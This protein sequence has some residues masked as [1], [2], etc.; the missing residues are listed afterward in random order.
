M[1]TRFLDVTLGV[2]VAIGLVATPAQASSKPPTS[3][4]AKQVAARAASTISLKVLSSSMATVTALAS[5]QPLPTPGSAT[6][7][8]AL[9]ASST[10]IIRL[11]NALDPT[12]NDAP[13]DTASIYY[14]SS[15]PGCSTTTQCV[16]GDESSSTTVVLYGDSHAQMWLP[17][18]AP[19]ATLDKF[20]LVL[21]WHPGCPVA[22]VPFSWPVCR[23]FRIAAIAAI[24]KLKPALILTGNKTTSI[25]GPGGSRITN[26]Q[27]QSGLEQTIRAL[28]T[29]TTK[30]V[31]I[32]DVTQMDSLVPVCLSINPSKI[33][34]CTVYNPNPKYTQRFKPEMAAAKATGATY[35]N[36]QSWLCNLK[37]S[38]VIGNMIVYSD[39]GH[40]TASY[41]EYLT[42]VWNAAIKNLV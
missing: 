42:N 21:V 4:S 19:I 1:K 30:V 8:A 20:R 17:V 35:V 9:V 13:F 26:A 18:L 10:S 2:L 24:V 36:P 12:V 11:P 28:Q 39:Q 16:Y 33:Q 6:T 25:V 7:I 23:L 32:G 40:V 34:K 31:V 14:K 37:C 22:N 41:A 27:W 38:P 5:K 29:K 3:A 15:A